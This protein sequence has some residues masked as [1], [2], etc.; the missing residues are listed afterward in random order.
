VIPLIQCS[1]SPRDQGLDQGLAL[2]GAVRDRVVRSGVPTPR[3]RRLSLA[4]F[5]GGP[6]LG[7]GLGREVIR[8]HTHLAERME[9]IALGAGLRL[10]SLMALLLDA[11]GALEVPAP[12]ALL[13]GAGGATT[14]LRGLPTDGR[15]GAVPLLRRS[16][17]DVGFASVEV[18][19]PWL[20]TA[21]A[22]VNEAGVVA[23]WCAG[24]R[25]G[26]CA[27]LVQEV[28]QRFDDLESAIDWSTKR[29]VRG[30]GALW[31]ATPGGEL[32]AV[33]FLDRERRVV[34]PEDGVLDCELGGERR[35]ALRKA[36]ADG[37]LPSLRPHELGGVPPPLPGAPGAAHPAPEAPG[38][39]HW[40]R[41]DAGVRSLQLFDRTGAALGEPV[42]VEP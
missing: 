29:P 1:G 4:P 3:R 38:V 31:L 18:T 20:A 30:G 37:A 19:L 35:A 32:A 6:I 13:A 12:A 5:A 24:A 27:L 21:L 34:R 36:V 8:H 16:R 2:A 7:S 26:P 33:L 10:D 40:A 11:P 22:G 41:V 39:R 23:F 9:G 28:L 14:G 25:P 15:A 42:R 17:P